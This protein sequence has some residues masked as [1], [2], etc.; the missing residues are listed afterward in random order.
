MKV[1]K[2]IWGVV[3]II[4]V[5]L[6][7]LLFLNPFAW[8]MRRTPEYTPSAGLEKNLK[9]MQ[10]EINEQEDIEIDIYN[11]KANLWYLRDC[12]NLKLDSLEN[13]KIELSEVRSDSFIKEKINKYAPLIEKE[14][15]D[16]CYDS[17]IFT[18]KMKGNEL[19]EFVS[20]FKIK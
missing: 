14:I 4:S 15:G 10:N 1:L 7:M 5:L 18:Y 9:K 20:A 16:K 2:S 12:E 13:F 11:N 17:L 8:G 3:L 6:P 19:D